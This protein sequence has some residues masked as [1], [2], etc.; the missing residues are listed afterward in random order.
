MRAEEVLMLVAGEPDLATHVTG[1]R[2]VGERRWDIYLDGRIEVR[3]P[4]ARPEVA[5]RRLAAEQRATAVIARAVT[6]VDLRNPDWLTLELPDT[7]IQPA[8]PRA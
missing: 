6:A 4:A 7:T 2:L 3:L 1:A 5:W 8:R